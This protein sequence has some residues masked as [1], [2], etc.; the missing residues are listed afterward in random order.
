MSCTHFKSTVLFLVLT[1][2]ISSQKTACIKPIFGVARIWTLLECQTISC[3]NGRDRIVVSTS[4]CGRDNPGSNPGHGRGCEV[5]I[6]A[7][8][9][10]N[11]SFTRAVKHHTYPYFQLLPW[12][13]FVSGSYYQYFARNYHYLLGIVVWPNKFVAYR[14]NPSSIY[15]FAWPDCGALLGL[16]QVG[17]IVLENTTGPVV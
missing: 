17:C 14:F 6:M 4:R 15:P 16:K 10:S 3:L 7:L 11:F 13:K 8:P 12:V 5:S 2:I 9:D 1:Y